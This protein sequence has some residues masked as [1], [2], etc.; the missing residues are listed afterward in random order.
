MDY[1]YN[2]VIV[3]MI[4]IPLPFFGI[5]LTYGCTRNGAIG[6]ETSSRNSGVIHA[7][8]YY[9]PGSLKALSC[10]RGNRLLYDYCKDKHVSHAACGK[11]ILAADTDQ[12]QRL[13]A[14]QTNANKVKYLTKVLS[15]AYASL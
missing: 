13:K 8:I 3:A 10:I 14:L 12:Q 4:N 15:F 5:V 2:S 1:G 9:P 6:M 11:I 7:G